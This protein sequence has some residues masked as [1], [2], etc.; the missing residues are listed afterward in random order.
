MGV[1]GDYVTTNGSYDWNN[2]QWIVVH[3]TAG[4]TGVTA[5]ANAQY[6]Y[7]NGGSVQCGT[8]YFIGDD[9][10]FQSTPEDRGAWTNG[11]Y[12]A[13]THAISL[14]V[15]C[16]TYE[17]CFT[18]TEREY[19]REMVCDLMSRY[20]I[21]TDHV[22]RHY[23]VVDCFSGSTVDPHK[24]CPRPYIDS[25]AWAELHDY[26]T[27][28]QEEDVMA[29]KEEVASAVLGHENPNMEFRLWSDEM[30]QCAWNA[31]HMLAYKNKAV[32]GDKDVYQLMTDAAN[33]GAKVDAL[34]KKV[35]KLIAALAK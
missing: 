35:D 29:T 22:I 15:A 3:Y 11:N 4:A 30:Y 19:L 10:V 18:N 17:D 31:G 9:G 24:N 21:D 33:A 23:D 28:N 16:G 6:Y 34:E 7:N 20:G 25:D 2:P 5:R 1:N 13:N 27:N 26:I 32:N 14:E 8:H 12:E